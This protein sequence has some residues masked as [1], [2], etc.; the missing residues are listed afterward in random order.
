MSS[1]SNPI[2]FSDRQERQLLLDMAAACE[3]VYSVPQFLKLHQHVLIGLAQDRAGL[4]SW[5]SSD[6]DYSTRFSLI[7]LIQDESVDSHVALFQYLDEHLLISVRG[8]ASIINTI[9]DIDLVRVKVPEGEKYHIALPYFSHP[10]SILEFGNHIHG[11]ARVHQGFLQ[12][13]LSVSSQLHSDL[14][15]F[16]QAHP[17]AKVF[18]TGHSLGAAV[19]LFISLSIELKLSLVSSGRLFVATF[20]CPRVGNH[21]WREVQSFVRIL[22]IITISSFWSGVREVVATQRLSRCSREGHNHEQPPLGIGLA[23]CRER[24]SDRR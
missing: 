20:G 9:E 23:P 8:T 1:V 14:N 21:E 4:E 12:Q 10:S 13:Y 15:K 11:S 18:V 5:C 19:S 2:R 22:K 7:S 17:K 24:L 3:A 6:P 16:M